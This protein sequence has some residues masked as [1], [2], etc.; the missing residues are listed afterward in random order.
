[1]SL[2]KEEIFA[3]GP[4][5]FFKA[6]RITEFGN[7]QYMASVKKLHN[8]IRTLHQSAILKWN[9]NTKNVDYQT[10]FAKVKVK[11]LNR[12]QNIMIQ[13]PFFMSCWI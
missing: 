12:F 2:L 10:Y 6:N 5:A 3:C 7:L 13:I 11:V 9:D 4:R 8:L 1:M